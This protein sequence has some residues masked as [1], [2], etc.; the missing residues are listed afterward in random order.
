VG[1]RPAEV[2]GW[3]LSPREHAELWPFAILFLA[4][5]LL[6]PV[7][8]RAIDTFGVPTANHVSTLSSQ[9]AR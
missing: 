3:D 8:M 2:H 1:L 5:G 6:S 4:M 9:E 7:W